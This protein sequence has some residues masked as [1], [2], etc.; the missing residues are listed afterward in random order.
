[1]AEGPV[2]IL[3]EHPGG[4]SGP[5]DRRRGSCAFG[6]LGAKPSFVDSQ[7]AMQVQVETYVGKGGAEQIRQFRFDSRVIE[8]ADNIDQW[9][10]A[11]YRYVKVRGRDGGVYIL[12]QNEIEAEWEL[13]MYQRPL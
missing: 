10:G 11:G 1:M 12:R 8:V 6:P 2:A 3:S 9:H 4:D 5:T 7:R 13:T